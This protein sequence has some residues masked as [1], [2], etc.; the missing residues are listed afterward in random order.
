MPPSQC[1]DPGAIPGR[2]TSLE[3]GEWILLTEAEIAWTAA[4]IDGEGWVGAR[5]KPNRHSFVPTVE[6][7]NNNGTF[8][9]RLHRYW[10]GWS[11]RPS[12]KHPLRRWGLEH[13]RAGEMLKKVLPWLVVKRRQAFVAI[14]LADSIG[15][16]YQRLSNRRQIMRHTAYCLLKYLN[17]PVGAVAQ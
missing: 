2:G 6:V 14:M 3:M 11:G 12:Q 7:S 5:R 8:I 10:G 1:G 16:T 4:A 9:S 17:R 13:R 15:E